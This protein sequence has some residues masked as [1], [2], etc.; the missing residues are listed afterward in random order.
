MRNEHRRA[1]SHGDDQ[2]WIATSVVL[3]L[4]SCG[5]RSF[6]ALLR[7]TGAGQAPLAGALSQ[8]RGDG[9][10]LQDAH[11][12]WGLSSRGLDLVERSRPR[13]GRQSRRAA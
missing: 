11:G 6:D 4:S 9:F 13:G 12:S 1:S 8:L 5:K 3:E 10:I 2:S 7:S